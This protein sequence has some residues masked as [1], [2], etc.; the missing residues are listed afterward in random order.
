MQT[1]VLGQGTD[2]NPPASPE[3]W[4]INMGALHDRPFH[5]CAVWRQVRDL[6][7]GDVAAYQALR[8]IVAQAIADL[9]ARLA[10]PTV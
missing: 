10:R 7:F 1:V 5:I 6:D 3:V 8:D 9:A 2:D 4:S